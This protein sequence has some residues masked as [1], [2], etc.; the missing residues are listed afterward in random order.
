MSSFTWVSKKPQHDAAQPNI[1][2][3][4]DLPNEHVVLKK[5]GAFKGKLNITAFVKTEF[6]IEHNVSDALICGVHDKF[7]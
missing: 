1:S 4:L 3:N 2:G 5:T 6:M 7:Q